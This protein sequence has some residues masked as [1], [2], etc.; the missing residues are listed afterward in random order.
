LKFCGFDAFIIQGA[1]KKLTYLHIKDGGAELKDATSLVYKDTWETEDAIKKEL[2]T[3]EHQ[4]SVLCIGP[5][6]E[7]KVRFA[8]LVGDRGHVAAHNGIGAVL[9]SKNLKAIAVDRGSAP[10]ALASKEIFSSLAKAIFERLINTYD[11]ANGERW[12]LNSMRQRERRGAE[13]L[14]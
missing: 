7:N 10:V 11:P 9:G 8:C 6:G 12:V 3:G 5:A 4:S 13:Y 2:G 1:A 14:L